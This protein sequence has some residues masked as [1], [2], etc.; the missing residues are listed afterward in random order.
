MLHIDTTKIAPWTKSPD[1]GFGESDAKSRPLIWFTG[2]TKF[3]WN[4]TFRLKKVD[5]LRLE[6]GAGTQNQIFSWVGGINW[7]MGYV[8]VFP[9]F[10]WGLLLF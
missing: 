4:S 5:I 3:E 9:F 1:P 7:R 10:G 6:S 2:T 8:F